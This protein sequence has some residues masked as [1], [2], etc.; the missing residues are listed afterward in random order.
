MDQ[1]QDKGK[2]GWYCYTTLQGKNNR[3]LSVICFY[4]SCKATSSAGASTAHSQATT[5][6]DDDRIAGELDLDSTMT[7]R[8]AAVK[9]LYVSSFWKR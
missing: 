5:L 8:E 7:P 3:K 2:K 9:E 4:H 1:G 6:M